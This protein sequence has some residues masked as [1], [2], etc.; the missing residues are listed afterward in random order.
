[1]TRPPASD[2]GPVIG[3]AS[4]GGHVWHDGFARGAAI[5]RLYGVFGRVP[6]MRTP[7]QST[8]P[9]PR[10]SKLLARI[11]R[12][13]GTVRPL[14]PTDPR[15]LNHPSHKEQWLELARA[16][17]RAE[18]RDEFEL[19]QRQRARPDGKI[20]NRSAVRPFFK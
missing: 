5:M 13:K 16:M 15:N 18:A 11:A 17:G 19:R 7:N 3:L 4:A 14:D 9:T 10:S 8:I 2:T 20:A 6:D 1:M 12:N